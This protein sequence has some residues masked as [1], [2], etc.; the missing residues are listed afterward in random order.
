MLNSANDGSEGGEATMVEEEQ[1]QPQSR[2]SEIRMV[3][4][5]TMV[6]GWPSIYCMVDEGCHLR[7][8]RVSDGW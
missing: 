7:L 2:R 5:K 8:W 3:E 1:Q 4:K 6:G